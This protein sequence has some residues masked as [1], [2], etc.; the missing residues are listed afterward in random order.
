MTCFGPRAANHP[1]SNQIKTDDGDVQHYRLKL[2]RLETHRESL[3]IAYMT[4]RHIDRVRAVPKRH[5][6]FPKREAFLNKGQDG[7]VVRFRWERYLGYV[8]DPLSCSCLH[9]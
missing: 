3:R 4:S 2:E 8:R 1:G 6:E 9:S 7:G 5:L